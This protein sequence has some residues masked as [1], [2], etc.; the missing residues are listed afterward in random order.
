[1]QN[2][3]VMLAEKGNSFTSIKQFFSNF[4]ADV[5]A[6]VLLFLSAAAALLFSN[7]DQLSQFYTALISYPIQ[8]SSSFL[9][10]DKNLLLFVN[11][12]LMAIFFFYVGLEIKR[13]FVVG[14]LSSTKKAAFSVFAAIGGMLFPALLYVAFNSGSASISGWGIPMATDIAFALGILALLGKRVPASLKAFLLALAIVDDLGA[15]LVIA[16]FYTANI[17][18]MA[19]VV[20]FSVLAL[21]MTLNRFKLSNKAVGISLGLVVWFAF[22]KSGVHATIA[23]VLLAMITP[24]VISNK[25]SLA[26]N[27]DGLIHNMHPWISFAILPLFAFFNAG[28]DFRTIDVTSALNSP[29]TYGIVLG[30]LVGKP[31]GVFLMS[32][33]SHKLKIATKPDDI[34][35][36]Q[37]LGVGVVSA[38]G[39]TMS[40][41]IASLAFNSEM[42]FSLS[43]VAIYIASIL[44]MIIGF[45]L[46]YFSCS[47]RNP[48]ITNNQ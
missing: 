39:F 27:F 44:A 5:A 23:G 32:Y 1:M 16:L 41:F 21:L 40:L 8:I 12:G 47:S 34:S 28:I 17:N 37:V 11:D 46:L 24:L 20:A 31:L 10:L 36:M 25:K 9:S 15:I 33:I 3:S 38:I 48:E 30:L 26:T 2:S 6:G 19:L 18:F 35:W 29:I 43:K 45:L 4:N 13:E 42:D 14:D 22:L 7:S